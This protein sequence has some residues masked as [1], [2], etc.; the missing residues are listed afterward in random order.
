M[1]AILHTIGTALGNNVGNN[2]GKLC[3][4]SF[5]LFSPLS[6]I[7][8]EMRIGKMMWH[9][10]AESRVDSFPNIPTAHGGCWADG[11]RCLC[12]VWSFINSSRRLRQL[13]LGIMDMDG[14]MGLW[15]V[16]PVSP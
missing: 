1:T 10:V 16:R 7:E 5:Q 13:K 12:F 14:I 9:A 2:V 11:G 6:E 8:Q 15:E 3:D 4:T